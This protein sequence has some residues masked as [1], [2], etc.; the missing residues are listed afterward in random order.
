MGIS[1]G[2][3]YLQ[4]GQVGDQPQVRPGGLTLQLVKQTYLAL[5]V[6]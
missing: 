2:P 4:Q 1:W 6:L 5:G 3:I